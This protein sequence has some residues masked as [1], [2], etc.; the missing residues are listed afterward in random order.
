MNEVYI[1]TSYSI[2]FDYRMPTINFEE[3]I[4]LAREM[5]DFRNNLGDAIFS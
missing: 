1:H 2:L 5:K 3:K 4:R